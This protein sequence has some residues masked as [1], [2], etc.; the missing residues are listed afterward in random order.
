MEISPE[1]SQRK[2]I[3]PLINSGFSFLL[4][5]NCWSTICT[6]ILLAEKLIWNNW[7]VLFENVS[8]KI[9]TYEKGIT[10]FKHL[11]FL[12]R[13]FAKWQSTINFLFEL[14]FEIHFEFF[15][16]FTFESIMWVVKKHWLD[17]PLRSVL[18]KR[19]Y[20]KF[21]TNLSVTISWKLKLFIECWIC[22]TSVGLIIFN[23]RQIS[24]KPN[25]FWYPIVLIT[26]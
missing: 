20:W 13:S 6:L 26:H 3:F 15:A 1:S 14:E 19:V 11:E 22:T 18:L 7:L 9:K 17:N 21:R 24:C 25:P 12:F 16:V 2:T 5:I 4:V 10:S 23:R 8:R